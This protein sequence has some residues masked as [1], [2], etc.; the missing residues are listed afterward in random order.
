MSPRF[1]NLNHSLS[2]PTTGEAIGTGIGILAG[3]IVLVIVGTVVASLFSVRSAK[4]RD[5]GQWAASDPI[6]GNWYK[7]LMQ[8]DNPHMSCCG[9]ADAY[10]ADKVEVV[11][12]KVFATITD[13]RDDRYWPVLTPSGL[14]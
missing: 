12:G 13:T 10:W 8:P 3:V 11:D 9:K 2:G 1:N 14:I 6:I 7:G 4:A 5:V